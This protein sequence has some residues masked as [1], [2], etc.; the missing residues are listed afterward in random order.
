MVFAQNS[1]PGSSD[2]DL[3]IHSR[4]RDPSPGLELNSNPETRPLHSVSGRA[5]PRITRNMINTGAKFCHGWVM[6]DDTL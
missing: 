5:R 3:P 2:L 1:T 4:D 6:N